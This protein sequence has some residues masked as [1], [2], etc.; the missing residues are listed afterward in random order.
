M[1]IKAALEQVHFIA[2]TFVW[3][4]NHADADTAAPG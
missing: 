1:Q 4:V 2:P 3:Q